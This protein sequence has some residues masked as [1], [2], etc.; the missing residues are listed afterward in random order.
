MKEKPTLSSINQQE[1]M[2]DTYLSQDIAE[3]MQKKT[4]YVYK[5]RMINYNTHIKSISGEEKQ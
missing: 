3:D 5:W 4:K 2:K 1:N